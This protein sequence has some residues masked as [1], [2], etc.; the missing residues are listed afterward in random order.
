ME[1]EI[2]D[3]LMNALINFKNHQIKNCINT[4]NM[5]HN[6]MLTMYIL[7]DLEENNKVSLLKLRKNMRLAPS[8]ITPIITSLEKDGLILR[9]IDES[10]RRNI[11]LTLTK[12]GREHTKYIHDKM[13]KELSEYIEYMGEDTIYS[14]IDNINKTIIFFEERKKKEWKKYLVT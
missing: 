13:Q 11:F 12:K 5:T 10:D 6:Q 4:P 8:T 2:I 1:K 7:H 3:E 14:L 9:K